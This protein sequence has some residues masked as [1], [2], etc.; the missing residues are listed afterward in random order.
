MYVF[1][2]FLVLMGIKMWQGADEDASLDDNKL[3]NWLKNH[4][5]LSKDYDG[6]KFLL[7]KMAN[8]WQ[9][10]IL[11]FDFVELSDVIF[12]VD[13]IPAILRL[14]ATHLLF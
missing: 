8:V 1:G 6:E 4:I 12:A 10:V 3:L 2:A 14:L 7:G 9:R 13:S 5:P 11:G